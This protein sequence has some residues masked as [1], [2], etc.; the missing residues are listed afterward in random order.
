MHCRIQ[1]DDCPGR[2]GAWAETRLVSLQ[3][4]LPSL[5]IRPYAGLKRGLLRGLPIP[6]VSSPTSEGTGGGTPSGKFRR[7]AGPPTRAIVC[8]R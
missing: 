4:Q 7:F 3:P 6:L 1:R 2:P 5:L 8:A